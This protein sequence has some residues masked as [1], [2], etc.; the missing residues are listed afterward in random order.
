ML[1][2]KEGRYNLI[3]GLDIEIFSNDESH[4]I[5]IHNDKTGTHTSLS[6]HTADL[7][8]LGQFFI[9]YAENKI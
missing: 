3:E 9:D 5:L 6:I 1:V 4:Y 8:D 2:K 7:Q